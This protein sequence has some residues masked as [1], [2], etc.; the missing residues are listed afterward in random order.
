MDRSMNRGFLYKYLHLGCLT[1]VF[2]Q[3]TVLVSL[4][5]IYKITLYV[6]VSQKGHDYCHCC[7]FL[8]TL[9]LLEMVFDPFIGMNKK[10]N[11]L[12]FDVLNRTL[13]V[14]CH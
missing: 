4:Q 2:F 8:C 7:S 11:K 13:F 5:F 1:S 10:E 14:Q 6:S 12:Q 9:H 3:G